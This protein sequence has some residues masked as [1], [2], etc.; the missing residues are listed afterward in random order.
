MDWLFPVR[1][2]DESSF[3]S[4]CPDGQLV[5][6]SIS[7]QAK[8]TSLGIGENLRPLEKAGDER[9]VGGAEADDKIEGFDKTGIVHPHVEF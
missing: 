5:G 3:H 9:V 8:L 7:C 1:A 6:F 2:L 4:W